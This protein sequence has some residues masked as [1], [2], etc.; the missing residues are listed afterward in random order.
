V[1]PIGR[2]QR[3]AEWVASHLL[4]LVRHFHHAIHVNDGLRH[5]LRLKQKQKQEKNDDDDDGNFPSSFIYLD[6]PPPT[7]PNGEK[8][9]ERGETLG[10]KDYKG[11]LTSFRPSKR[12]KRRRTRRRKTS[13]AF[14]F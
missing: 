14:L 9:S 11:Q 12:E 1:D 2:R 7:N 10:E 4:R 5:R 6:F 3:Q 8:W 13:S